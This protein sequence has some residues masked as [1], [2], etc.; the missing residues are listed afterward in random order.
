MGEHNGDGGNCG[1]G[2]GERMIGAYNKTTMRPRTL[3]TR[4]APKAKKWVMRLA[5]SVVPDENTA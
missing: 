1:L 3:A 2:A 5:L 4:V